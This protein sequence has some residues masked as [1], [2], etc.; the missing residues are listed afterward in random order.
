MPSIS[1]TLRTT[2]VRYPDRVALV[3]ADASMT[4]RE[5]NEQVERLAAVLHSRGVGKGDRVLLLGGNS[6]RY[7]L[8]AYA[9]L[10]AGAILVP[11]N[12]LSAAPELAYLL[13]DSG[14]SVVLFSPDL[15]DLAHKGTALLSD[16]VIDLLAL[17]RVEGAAD[18][19]ELSAADLEPV[20]EW[21]SESDDAM[22]LYTSGTTGRPKG[23][24]FDHH[25]IIWTGVNCMVTFGLREAGRMLHVAPMYHSA[26]LCIMLFPGTL[27][28]STHVILPGFDPVLVADALAEHR[29]TSF[30]GVPTMYQFLLRVPGFAD[31]DLSS[32][33]TA[34]F[35]AAPMPAATV[36]QLIDALP[37]VQLYSLC[38]QTEGGP[39][40]IY[41]GPEDVLSRPDA[42][43]RYPLPNTEVRIVDAEGRDIQRGEI[44]ELLLRGET[45][46][47]GYWNNPDATAAAVQDGWL[48]TG[49]LAQLD[50]D[51]Y[52]T[53]V[54]RLKDMIITGGRN[55]Y[56]VEVENAIAGHPDV[57]DVAV[58]GVPH[59]EYGESILAI[60]TLREG[61]ELTLE[62]LRDWSRKQIALYKVP[63]ALL[64]HSI[65]RNPSGKIQKHILRAELDLAR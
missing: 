26:E 47:K 37:S 61:A 11:A 64:I 33:Q 13:T 34:A 3:F 4:Y 48:H 17:G 15:S 31:R 20:P 28:G 54:D 41:S 30:F 24:L 21:P 27:L 50:A 10:R 35:G 36:R 45:V 59:P 2:A 44:G 58:I 65:P 16:R 60:L 42:S 53:L 12:P 38:G 49:D 14:A 7:V 63:H 39:G 5:F 18:I 6:D 22:L 9:A 57:L 19:F 43:G 62:S 29:I 23:A 51:G 25:R 1:E 55:V 52:I 56:S 46:M 8:G 32:W 40:G